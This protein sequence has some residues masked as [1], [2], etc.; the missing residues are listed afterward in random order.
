MPLP[1]L[2]AVQC[3]QCRT[4]HGVTSLS[5]LTIYGRLVR[6]R[7]SRGYTNDVPK[8]MGSEATPTVLC[9]NHRCLME[10]LDPDHLEVL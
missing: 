7:G 5:Y 1:I 10:F 3:A 8:D 9:D 6:R 2:E 4:L